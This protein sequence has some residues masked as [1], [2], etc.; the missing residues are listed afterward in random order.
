MTKKI[1]I[2]ALHGSRE[3]HA[4]AMEKLGYDIVFLR[5]EKDFKNISGIILPGGES[6]SFGRLLEWSGIRNILEKKILEE[7][8]PTF[9]TCAGAILL[10]K[11][12]SEYSIGAIDIE[13]DRN[14]YGR[15]VDSFSEEIEIR[16]ESEKFHALFIRAPKI[17]ATG[18]S[19][20][21]LAKERENPVLVQNSQKNILVSTFHP[22]LTN[23]TRIHEIFAEMIEK[24]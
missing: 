19:V 22:E 16:G 4:K 15:Q 12:G 18:E 14:A 17:I 10:A 13:I 5:E 1:G 7:N 24:I 6:S 9:G 3:E 21:I 11:K 23:D 2:L 8:I 20:E